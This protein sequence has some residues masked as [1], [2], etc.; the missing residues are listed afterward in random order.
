MID[1]IYHRFG[2]LHLLKYAPVST[3][4]FYLMLQHA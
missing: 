2:K 1:L 4:A 3:G